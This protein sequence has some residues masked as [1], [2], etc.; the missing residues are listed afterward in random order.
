MIMSEQ[1]FER[2]QDIMENAGELNERVSINQLVD[3]KI[4]E[5]TYKKIFG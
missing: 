2:L 5:D 1:A 3:N 4:A